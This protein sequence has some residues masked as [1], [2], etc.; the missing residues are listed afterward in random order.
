MKSINAHAG[1]TLI[2]LMIVVAIIGILAATA[3]PLYQK[4]VAESQFA[5]VMQETAGLKSLVESCVNVGKI[6]VGGGA[7]ECDPGAVPS[8]LLTGASQVGAVVPANMGVPQVT[9]NVGGSVDI[10]STFGGS[11]FPGFITLKLVWRRDASGSWTCLTSVDS[12]YRSAGCSTD[13]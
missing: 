12:Q 5:R 1:F 11:A 4:Y 7:D 2:E 3:L 13:L 8:T 6:V 9:I 10:E